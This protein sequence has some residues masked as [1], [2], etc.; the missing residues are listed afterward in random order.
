MLQ[1]Q[2]FR[3]K[4]KLPEDISDTLDPVLDPRLRYQH[5]N[6]SKA[7]LTET[8]RSTEDL[9]KMHEAIDT[10]LKKIERKDFSPDPRHCN[11][12]PYN[13]LDD[14]LDPIC[15]S[16]E[17]KTNHGFPV[18]THYFRKRNWEIKIDDKA[19]TASIEGKVVATLSIEGEEFTTSL[20]VLKDLKEKMQ[21]TIEKSKR[22]KKKSNAK[23]DM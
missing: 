6:A 13:T 21:K 15:R 1:Q 10:F 19:A 23:K 4:F 11:S 14:L 5:F 20:P 16:K 7:V 3:L 12:C 18:P 22:E 9:D 8:S 17:R 2:F